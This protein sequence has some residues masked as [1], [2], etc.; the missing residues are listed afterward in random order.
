MCPKKEKSESRVRRAFDQRGCLPNARAAPASA[1]CLKNPEEIF[2]LSL[3]MTNYSLGDVCKRI[4]FTEYLP[5]CQSELN[6]IQWH[7]GNI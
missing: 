3:H 5:Y 4:V 7:G 2:T 1:F 6:R